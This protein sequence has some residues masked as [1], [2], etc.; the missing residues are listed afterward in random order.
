[1]TMTAPDRKQR[2]PD[3]SDVSS[4]LLG[5]VAFYKD[6]ATIH[7]VSQ[8]GGKRLY[9]FRRKVWLVLLLIMVIGLTTLMFLHF[10]RFSEH[11]TVTVVSAQVTDILPFPAVTICNL[12]Q[13]HRNRIP[14]DENLRRLLYRMSDYAYIKDYITSEAVVSNESNADK[15]DTGDELRE[16]CVYRI[17]SYPCDELFTRTVTDLGVCYTFNADKD[18]ERRNTTDSGSL[19]GLRV[20]LNIE[21]DNYYYSTYSQSGI[22][23]VLHE[24]D[25]APIMLNRGFFVRP[26]TC[27]DVAI[28]REQTFR[29]AYP[30]KAFGH[31]Y[32]V[33]TEAADFETPLTRYQN[34]SYSG[35]TCLRDCF[36]G[37]LVEKCG[38]RHFY[39]YG[40]ED[41]CSVEQLQ[42]CYLPYQGTLFRT[43]D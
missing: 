17:T 31:S 34:F 38:C 30:Y 19:N 3:D 7:G 15:V 39:E 4:E 41:F 32:C 1:M 10:Q 9:S 26:G 16:F 42:N 11:P 25:E 2:D 22:K 33:D 14:R 23:V 40:T 13:F 24:P 12:N 35:I 18:R 37:R 28:R 20:I 27:T 36:V 6:T 8:I 29:L 21:Q 43:F 5:L